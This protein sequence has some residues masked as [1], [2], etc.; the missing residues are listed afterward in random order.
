MKTHLLFIVVLSWVLP[1]QAH[2]HNPLLTK[3]LERSQRIAQL[4]QMH[5]ATTLLQAPQKT[6]RA[7]KLPSNTLN[8]SWE[9]GSWVAS[10]RKDMTYVNGGY[11]KELMYSKI[12]G[13]TYTPYQKEVLLYNSKWILQETEVY[14]MADGWKLAYRELTTTDQHDNLVLDAHVQWNASLTRWDTLV[15]HRS[16]YEYNAAGNI[17]KQTDYVTPSENTWVALTQIQMTYDAQG[18]ITEYLER[19][20]NPGTNKFIDV[21][22]DEYVYDAQGRW[23][24]V[25][26]YEYEAGGWILDSKSADFQ[27]V[28]FDQE[29]ASSFNYYIYDD[30][31]EQWF[32]FMRVSMEFASDGQMT[33]FFAEMYDG[34]AWQPAMRNITRYENDYLVLMTME[35]HTGEAWMM[36][37]GLRNNFTWNADGS[38][39][40]GIM[41]VYNEQWVNVSKDKFG[42]ETV[43]VNVGDV[44]AHGVRVYPNPT[45]GRLM[46]EG[47]FD[48]VVVYNIAG[49]V[50]MER[51]PGSGV[52][53]D[54]GQLRDGVYF[55][56]VVSGGRMERVKV[57][58]R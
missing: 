27:W 48:R 37:F 57:L 42:Y 50:V 5:A 28:N 39:D 31:E 8:Y 1:M 49:Q 30:E 36:W 20:W 19:E 16:V 4:P 32:L 10:H 21:M 2:H 40:E 55:V 54:L 44:V 51:E 56:G 12:D 7:A 58:K 41:Q 47:A 23:K 43:P 11:L 38:P 45:S 33:L 26:H 18:R 13:S 52:M 25:L 34:M 6:L 3:A 17:V 46:V 29:M 53:L 9:E 14:H 35:I 24:E 22:R 15:G